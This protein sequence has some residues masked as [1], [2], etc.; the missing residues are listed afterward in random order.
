MRQNICILTEGNFKLEDIYFS[1]KST[2]V[3][4][5]SE[6]KLC[7]ENKWNTYKRNKPFLFNGQLFHIENYK[8]DNSRIMLWTCKSSFKKYTGTN[9]DN[10]R[11]LFGQDKIIRPISVGTMI[12]TSDNKWIVG[13]RSNTYDYQ[14]YYTLIA[15]FMDPTRDII[16]SKP[17]PFHA[18]KREIMEESGIHSRNID[19]IM[20]IGLVGQKQ[21]YL[22][23]VSTLNIPF[24]EFKDTIP[25]EK[26][27]KRL[28]KVELTRKKI[29]KFLSN[30]YNAMT[31]HAL[32]NLLLYHSSKLSNYR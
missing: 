15:G 1:Y 31:P 30:N 22:A 11:R 28:E 26:E 8:F 32:A 29:E 7:I 17:D 2:D 21:P 5:S 13:I 10:F 20:C 6:E 18:L 27:F 9:S 14:G 19:S 4:F 25:Q 23:F 24:A 3:S 16:N 12:I